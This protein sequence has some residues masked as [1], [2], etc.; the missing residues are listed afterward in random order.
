MIHDPKIEVTCDGEGCGESIEIQ[1]DYKYLDYSG[2]NGF[3]DCSDTAIIKQ[4]ER[5]GWTEK[6]GKTFCESCG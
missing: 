2:K 5:D 4:L 3:Y 6:D 1:P